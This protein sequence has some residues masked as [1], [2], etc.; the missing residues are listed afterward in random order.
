MEDESDSLTTKNRPFEK[1]ANA[2]SC[3]ALDEKINTGLRS[4]L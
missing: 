3:Q 4:V 1:C 2:L